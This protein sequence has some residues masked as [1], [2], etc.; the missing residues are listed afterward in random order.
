MSGIALEKVSF[1]Y[2]GAPVIENLSLSLPAGSRSAVMGA[3]G[4]GKTTLLHIMAGLLLPQ[5]G[6]VTGIPARGVSV[7]FQEPRLLPWLTVMDNLLAAVPGG[8]RGRLTRLLGSLGLA[9]WEDALPGDLSGG[10]ARRVAIARALAFSSP[11]LLLDEP[12]AGLDDDSR[13]AA[14]GVINRE[15]AGATLVAIVHDSRDA[16]LLDC[17]IIRPL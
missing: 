13:I 5:K 12:F 14:A 7:V 6:S 9:G 3:S 10:M 17:R 16:Q 1:G 11:L 15:S 2:G 4:L 8:D